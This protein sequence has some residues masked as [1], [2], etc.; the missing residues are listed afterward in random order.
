MGPVI[1]YRSSHGILVFQY[2][3]SFLYYY[4]IALFNINLY[5]NLLLFYK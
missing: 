1:K 4:F 2:V 5:T 3:Y